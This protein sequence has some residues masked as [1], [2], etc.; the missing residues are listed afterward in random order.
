MINNDKMKSISGSVVIDDSLEYAFTS[1]VKID[2]AKAKVTLS[3]MVEIRRPGA[4]N[5]QL[6]GQFLK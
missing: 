3:P 5:M 1:E 2:N 6:S 4:K